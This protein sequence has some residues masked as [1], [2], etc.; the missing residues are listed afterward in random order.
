MA[1]EGIPLTEIARVYPET[2]IKYAPLLREV[3]RKLTVPLAKEPFVFYLS[4]DPG[5]GKDVTARS[6]AQVLKR[7]VYTK[8]GRAQYFDGYDEHKC[9]VFSEFVSSLTNYDVYNS[10]MDGLG[11]SL[12]VKGSF[13]HSKADL[14]IFTSNNR[15][16]EAYQA[17]PR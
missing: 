11:D 13:V 1:S 16:H 6:I 5:T 9:I 17:V 14:V 12:P 2:T 8:V 3:S 4:G 7:D 15:S 10:I